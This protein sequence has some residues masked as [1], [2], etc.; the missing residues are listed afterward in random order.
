MLSVLSGVA[1]SVRML[2][3]FSADWSLKRGAN[4][5]ISRFLDAQ[6][7]LGGVAELVSAYVGR[8]LE[9]GSVPAQEDMEKKGG[10]GEGCGCH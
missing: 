5:V 10:C 9:S 7:T 3:P 6:E 4:P 1:A 8:T 2:P